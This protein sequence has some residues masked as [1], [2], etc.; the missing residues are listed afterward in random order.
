MTDDEKE[1]EK[2]RESS[3]ETFER[4]QRQ[5]EGE[6]GRIGEGKSISEMRFHARSLLSS[7]IS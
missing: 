6:R 3:G 5:A 7:P 4:R 2:K 1:K